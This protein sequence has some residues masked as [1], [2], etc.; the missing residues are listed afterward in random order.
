[1]V[2]NPLPNSRPQRRGARKAQ[3]SATI[4][5]MS[6]RA[7]SSHEWLYPIQE[8]VFFPSHLSSQFAVS[9]MSLLNIVS[10]SIVS[11][12]KILFKIPQ[13][14]SSVESC[15]PPASP[16]AL[17][18]LFIVA[19]SHILIHFI[20]GPVGFCSLSSIIVTMSVL[21]LPVWLLCQSYSPSAF[22]ESSHTMT[23]AIAFQRNCA[24]AVLTFDAFKHDSQCTTGS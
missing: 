22:E 12:S 15:L 23:S 4:K 5:C 3:A 13:L 8:R 9:C 2:C 16:P 18:W 7:S 10:S 14:K 24:P 21:I 20:W 17:Y 11:P 1:M 6:F 19:G